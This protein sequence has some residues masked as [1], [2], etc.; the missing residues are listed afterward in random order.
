MDVI[1]PCICPGKQHETDTITLREHLDFRSAV[2]LRNAAVVARLDPELDNVDILAVLT[3]GYIVY[4]I[5]SWTLCDDE[6]RPLA[7]SRDAIRSL[8]LP[9]VLEAAMVGDAADQL[10]AMAVVIPLLTAASDSSPATPTEPSTSA[11]NDGQLTSPK[12]SRRSSTTT[13]PT[14]DTEVTSQS[15]VGVSS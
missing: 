2:A 12:P 13:I 11:T 10:Y 8:L 5:E 6:G 7:V 4:G 15:L 3:E 1:V 9:H 14:G